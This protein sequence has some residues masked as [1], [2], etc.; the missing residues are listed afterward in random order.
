MRSVPCLQRVR[1]SWRQR[2]RCWEKPLLDLDRHGQLPNPYSDLSAN[3]RKG[4]RLWLVVW[5]FL[6][7]PWA[8]TNGRNGAQADRLP[9]KF[10]Q[11]EAGLTGANIR[12]L[13]TLG[14]SHISTRQT[15]RRTCRLSRGAMWLQRVPPTTM[16]RRPPR[17]GSVQ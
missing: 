1:A 4:A 13:S 7:E 9:A 5:L 11:L 2:I 12:N 6:V 3:G 16:T 17:G 15:R 10:R 8:M 14:I